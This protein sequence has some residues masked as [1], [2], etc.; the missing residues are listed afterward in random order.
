[1]MLR[2]FTHKVVMVAASLLPNYRFF[3][4]LLAFYDENAICRFF[5]WIFVYF[6][7][8]DY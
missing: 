1:M 3:F 4:F 8:L 6:A 2:L 7:V 5:T